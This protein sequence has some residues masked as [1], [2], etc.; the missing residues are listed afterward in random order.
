M[1][2]CF[3][4]FSEIILKILYLLSSS[5][6]SVVKGKLGNAL[7]FGSGR[8]LETFNDSWNELVLQAGVLSLGLLSHNHKVQLLAVSCLDSIKG[9]KQNGFK[10]SENI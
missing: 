6:G 2:L 1:K 8:N 10:R 7:G 4:N 9:L 3:S 5:L